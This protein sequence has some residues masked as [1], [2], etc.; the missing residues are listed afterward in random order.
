[1]K[2]ELI[3]AAMTVTLLAAPAAASASPSPADANFGT[4]ISQCARQHG[5][6]GTHN[7]GVHH[8]GASGWI[9]GGGH[10]PT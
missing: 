9:P 2:R 5:F 8:L 10:C 3:A 7:P 6:S 1:M 4:H